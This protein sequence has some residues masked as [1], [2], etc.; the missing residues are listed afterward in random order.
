MNNYLIN[1]TGKIGYVHKNKYKYKCI[2][3][4]LKPSTKINPGG[5]SHKYEK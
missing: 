3:L 4:Y 1:D 2:Y 5:L